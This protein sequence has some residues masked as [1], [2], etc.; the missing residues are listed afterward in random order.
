MEVSSVLAVAGGAASGPEPMGHGTPRTCGPHCNGIGI[1]A[2]SA[3]LRYVQVQA[4]PS[5]LRPMTNGFT[6]A[7]RGLMFDP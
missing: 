2:A 7:A 1:L 4:I 5:N 6:A 3:P